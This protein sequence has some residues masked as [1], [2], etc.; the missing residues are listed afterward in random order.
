MEAWRGETEAR[1]SQIEILR[2]QTTFSIADWYPKHA[3]WCKS[4]LSECNI[5]SPVVEKCLPVVG[6]RRG[7]FDRV[8][9]MLGEC[10]GRLRCSSGGRSG[11]KM[12]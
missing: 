10:A 11:F 12:R 2:I 7:E 6:E 4:D 1:R 8:R 3:T 5:A 9:R